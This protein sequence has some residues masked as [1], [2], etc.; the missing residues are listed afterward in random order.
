MADLL[1]GSTSSTVNPGIAVDRITK[2]LTD[3]KPSF[4]DIFQAA[5]GAVAK[6]GTFG[7]QLNAIRANSIAEA[8]S[9]YDVLSKERSAGLDERKFEF[10]VQKAES[11]AQREAAKAGREAF[12]DFIGNVQNMYADADP[13]QKFEVYRYM[14]TLG[15]DENSSPQEF[16]AAL[17]DI[18]AKFGFI[19][20]PEKPEPGFTLSPGQQRFDAEGNPIAALPKGPEF[21]TPVGVTPTV[22]IPFEG[23]KIPAGIPLTVTPLV[24]QGASITAYRDDAGN[25]KQILVPDSALA[26]IQTQAMSPIGTPAQRASAAAKTAFLDNAIAMTDTLI[27]SVSGGMTTGAAQSIVS[28]L[29]GTVDQLSTLST[30]V[31]ELK[32]VA[33][34]INAARE[35]A[36][37]IGAE[38][39]SADAISEVNSRLFDPRLPAVDVL[40]DGIAVALAASSFPSDQRIPVEAI[41]AARKNTEIGGLLGPGRETA[42]FKLQ[43]V[44][45]RLVAARNSAASFASGAAG[46][47]SGPEPQGAQ[48]QPGPAGTP[49]VYEFDENGEL[50]RVE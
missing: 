3:N 35:E 47:G 6:P 24:G 29:Q 31:P 25:M 23:G 32:G 26:R 1:T 44:K 28:A 11:E 13:R 50:R 33:D 37:R 2:L 17:A 8:Q 48:A 22:D 46:A 5:A 39:D 10:E 4:G 12:A 9:L 45:D 40:E 16:R 34:I 7:E 15:I 18:S 38:G 36:G 21:G 27:N 30:V 42:A 43:A 14:N 49:P 19:P 20:P 41:K